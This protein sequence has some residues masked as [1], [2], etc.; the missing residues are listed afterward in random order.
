M[1]NKT[2]I[3][4]LSERLDK[5][6]DEVSDLM[7]SFGL[8]MADILKAGDIVAVPTVGNFE[9]KL[10]PERIALHPSTGR[11]LLVPPKITINFKPSSLLKQ[12][13]R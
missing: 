9:T 7:E 4:N 13:L 6:R 2:L 3:D 12:K 1:D 11:K 5:S 10:K 8:V